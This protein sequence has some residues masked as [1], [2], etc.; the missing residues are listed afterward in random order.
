MKKLFIALLVCIYM[1]TAVFPAFLPVTTFAEGEQDTESAEFEI[2]QSD[3]VWEIVDP[4]EGSGSE[5]PEE[6]GVPE[7][8][9]ESEEPG[10]PEEGDGSDEPDEPAEDTGSDESGAPEAG[11]GSD[12][13]DEPAEDSDNKEPSAPTEGEEI[14][15]IVDPD[16]TDV[17]WEII[18]DEL[19]LDEE[20]T[21]LVWQLYYD[22]IVE[23]GD[24]IFEDPDCY[25]GYEAAFEIIAWDNFRYAQDPTVPG[26]ETYIEKEALLDEQGKSIRVRIVGHAVDAEGQVWYQIEAA[27]GYVL[28]D[29]LAANPYVLQLAKDYAELS[30]VI[31]PL[32]G[33]FLGETVEFLKK[34]EA[35]TRFTEVSTADL[36]DFVDVMPTGEYWYGDAWYDLGDVSSW[37]VEYQYV[38][39]ESILLIPPEVTVAYETLCNAESA[40]ELEEIWKS[41]PESLQNKFTDKHLAGLEKRYAELG[42]VE[43]TAV[44]EYNGVPLNVSV[45]GPIPM[46]GVSLQVAPVSSA[47]V[48]NEGFDIRSATDIITALD[49]KMLRD[50]GSEWQPEAGEQ[51]TI[52]IDV[53]GLG[54]EDE[55]IVRLHHKHGDEIYTFD[56]FVVL[57]GKVTVGTNGFSTFAVTEVPNTQPAQN[58][59]EYGN[60]AAISMQVG[61]EKIFYV[62]T[63]QNWQNNRNWVGTWQV[64]DTSGAIFYEVYSTQEPNYNRG[65]YVPWIR[66]VA[67]KEATNVT[68]TFRYANITYNNNNQAQNVNNRGTETHSLTITAPKAADGRALY[69]KDDVNNSGRIIAT[70]VDGNG[71]EIENGLAGAALTWSR[72]DNK[73]IAPAAYEDGFYSVNIAKDHGGLVEARKNS[74][75]TYTAV[76]ILADG[77]QETARYTVHYQSEILNA[78]FEEPVMTSNS[79]IYYPN[80]WAGLLWK[81]TAPGTEGNLIRD[82]EFGT[83][84]RGANDFGVT[85]ASSGTQF[86]ELNAEEF[87]ALYQD[88]ISVPGEE[89]DWEFTHAPRRKQNWTTNRTANKMFIV[90]GPTEKAQELTTQQQ[91]E[92]LG[93][94]AKNAASTQGQAINNQFLNGQIPVTVTYD[95]ATYSVW[96]HDA[97]APGTNQTSNWTEL[98]GSYLV[99]D[100]QYRTRLFFVTDRTDNDYQNFGNLIDSA[101]AGQY[102]TYL[103]EYYEQT[104]EN[105]ELVTHR[106]DGDESSEALIYSDVKL[107]NY[108]TLIEKEGDYLYKILVN[109]A[110]YPYD[111]YYDTRNPEQAYLYVQ[112]YSG[113]PIDYDEDTNRTYEQYDIVLQ[114]FLRDTVVAVQKELEFPDTLSEV[115]KLQIMEDLKKTEDRGY[116]ASFSLIPEDG[117]KV[118]DPDASVV[119]ADRDPAGKYT[120]FVALGENPELEHSYRVEETSTTEIPGLVLES[121]TFGVKRYELGKYKDTLDPISY[122]ET[123]I[124]GDGELVSSA[125]RLEGNIKIAD[126]TVVNQ[127]KEKETTIYYKAI[128]NGKVALDE[129]AGP[130]Q[131]FEDTPTEKL[132]YYSGQAK[133]AEIHNGNGATFKGWYKDEACTIP[134]TAADGVFDKETGS[135]KPNANIINADEVTF[136]AKFITNSI[137][138]N[139]TNGEPGQSFVY[140]VSGTT[141]PKAGE[142][143]QQI[144]LYVTV[145]CGLDGTGSREILEVLNGNY[146][147]TEVDDWSWRYPG[148][149]ENLSVDKENADIYYANFGSSMDKPNWLSGLADAVQNVFKGVT[150]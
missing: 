18:L 78:S 66:I 52:A 80:G 137:V 121:V 140:H 102:M 146:T 4:V 136:Y 68:L 86:A 85:Q 117:G 126:V 48:M 56:I 53:A 99:P 81:T 50:D 36:P 118:T 74:P 55:S 83:V 32:K 64:T 100:K 20:E 93:A 142:T 69:L 114:V 115:H 84:S 11:D 40:Q 14:W 43:Y 27:P 5:E 33:M 72:S 92:A 61:E 148:N 145:T 134:V 144:D 57:D 141:T 9:S 8:G 88:I 73:L 44:V 19:D 104:Y 60:N 98:S 35:A 90:I 129:T 108:K 39:D 111:L 59:T 75:V 1:V 31:L 76:A 54:I 95:D 38:A 110:T 26:E 6:P 119:L 94:A 22:Y 24:K 106:L 135:F 107:N 139:R 132:L 10:A 28:P 97:G 116:K 112:K 45:S 2:I 15:E 41:M 82:I 150:S 143:P 71:N 127:Y 58:A 47:A 7:E 42:G 37:G 29:V 89:I 49:I 131:E 147:V 133:G 103:I 70:L 125:I 21:G 124:T 128:G 30:F 77:S 138:I 101:R 120:G 13:P 113:T 67:L 3:D 62:N 23:Q 46:S 123:Q 109:N 25:V 16:D 17:T 12:E 91:L 63:E 130:D 122:D 79:Y 105:G 149:T 65:M 51:V 96:Y 34:P 87:G